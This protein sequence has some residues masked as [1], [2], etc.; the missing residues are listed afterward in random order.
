MEY[1][2]Q[3]FTGGW[4]KANY[5]AAEIISRLETVVN[6]IPVSRVIIGWHISPSLYQEVGSWLHE[7][8]IRMLMWMPVFSET[9]EIRFCE[10]AVDFYGRPIGNYALQEGENFAFY[11][12]SAAESIESVI[13]IFESSFAG[14]GF[15]GVFLDKIRSQSF[16]A[17]VQG[18]LS[19]GCKRCE[20]IYRE[21]GLLLSDLRKAY[22]EKKDHLFD[23]TDRYHNKVLEDF[24]RIKGEII[25]EG[26]ETLC[27]YFH[28]QGL[29]TG[30]DLYAPFLSHLVG[31]DYALLTK[32]ADFIKPMMYRKT[33]APAGISFEYDL[34]RKHLPNAEGWPHPVFDDAFLRRELL[35]IQ[36][37]PVR[38]YSGI[39]I[40]YREDIART[41][42][43]YIRSS[44]AVCKEC[45]MDGAVLSWDVML[46]PD[47][48]LQAVRDL[49]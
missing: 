13:D 9:G 44:L 46:A 4:K 37:L 31:Q 48:H 30:L 11:C 43:E 26:V 5:T 8:G 40:N 45:G 22:E 38:K 36:N 24:F 29:E 19:C 6:T 21:K 2:V 27:M 17:G 3:I 35:D 12:P 23:R 34:L 42:P 47:T 49:G 39:E 33:N 7:H 28:G 25:A 20:K 41:D 10:E 16:A 15:D 32:E 1:I 18:V 14:C